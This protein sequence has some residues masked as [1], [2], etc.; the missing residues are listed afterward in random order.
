AGGEDHR[1]EPA[2]DAGDRE[3]VGQDEHRLAQV[4]AGPSRSVTA[5]AGPPCTVATASVAGT[6]RLLNLPLVCHEG[7]F[8]TCPHPTPQS[9]PALIAELED[10]DYSRARP[11]A[12]RSP[13]ARASQVQDPLSMM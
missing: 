11:Q 4:E 13:S 7:D 2:E 6:A 12:C 9:R 1:I 10:Q 8:L 5:I 3:E